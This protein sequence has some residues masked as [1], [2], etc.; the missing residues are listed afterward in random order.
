MNIQ[1]FKSKNYNNVIHQHVSVGILSDAHNQSPNVI[2]SNG[3]QF[4][5]MMKVF[6]FVI[7]F[8]NHSLLHDSNTA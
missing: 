2:P 4:L 1:L 8:S 5:S 7:S 6:A 3:P